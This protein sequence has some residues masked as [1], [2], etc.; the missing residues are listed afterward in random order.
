MTL[1]AKS[2]SLPSSILDDS[3]GKLFYELRRGVATVRRAESL[4]NQ[5]Q[6]LDIGFKRSPDYV[7]VTLF[8]DTS[9]L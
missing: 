7:E 4:P 3:P 8:F 5:S 9:P 6:L 2:F 1:L